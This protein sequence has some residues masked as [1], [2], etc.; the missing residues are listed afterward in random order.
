[1]KKTFSAIAL[2]KDG[3][4]LFVEH[5]KFYLEVVLVFGLIALAADWLREEGSMRLVDVVL[6][7]INM[8]ATW[9]GS[10]VLMKASLSVAARKQIAPDVYNLTVPTIVTLIVASILTGLGVMI[11]A[12][13]LIIPGIMFALRTSLTQYVI[14]DE[15]L[16]T[17]PAIKK[18]I[19]L[20]KGYSWSILRLIACFIV[21]AVISMF[22]LF[23]LGFIVLIPV[24]TLVM[25]LV[26]YKIKTEQSIVP[27]V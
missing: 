12:V 15:H 17:V 24:S 14:L 11:G 21:L 22:P 16:T 18:S 8:V 25:S 27:Q 7:V 20:T 19:A 3:W 23:G 13:L 1:M 2:L 26:Y 9:Y 6:S 4:N 5:K 10:V